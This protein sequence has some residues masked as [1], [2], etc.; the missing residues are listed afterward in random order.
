LK[1]PHGTRLSIRK[2][3]SSRNAIEPIDAG[4]SGFR[5]L[6]TIYGSGR[7]PLN[8]R[9]RVCD[10]FELLVFFA[11]DAMFFNPLQRR[12]ILSEAPSQIY[13]ITE[14]L[15]ARSRR[16]CPE[17]SRENP[18]DA[19]WQM[20]F[21]AFRPQTTREIKKV[22]ASERT[23][24]ENVAFQCF[25]SMY[26]GSRAGELPFDCRV[27]TIEGAAPIFLGPSTLRPGAPVQGVGFVVDSTSAPTQ[28]E[29]RLYE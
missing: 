8:V 29:T 14:G 28:P 19:C 10:F 16:A 18:G 21:A 4:L 6:T 1:S 23:W 13:R 9:L 26:H 22:T 20:L 7:V 15:M 11:P 2:P 5:L 25:H 3:K 17:S 24:A 27:R 12:V